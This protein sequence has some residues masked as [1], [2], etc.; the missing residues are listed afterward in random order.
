[1][2]WAIETCN[3]FK[4]YDRI[5]AITDLTLTVP[6][7]SV[8]GLIGPNGAGKSTL[9]RMLTGIVRPDQ[10]DAF[11][12]GRSIKEKTGSIRQRVG[13][14]PDVPTLYPSFSVADMFRLGCRL[15]EGWDERRCYE[16]KRVFGLPTGQ[17]VR[18]LSRSQKVQL[19]LVMALSLRPRLLILDEPTAGLDPVIRRG[20]LQSVIEEVAERGTTVFYSTHN[21]NDLEQSADHI[22]ALHQGN[23]LFSRSLD[24]LKESIHRLQVMFARPQ[25]E[26][27]LKTIPGLIDCQHKGRIFTLTVSGELDAIK[28]QPVLRAASLVEKVDLSLEEMFVA[29]MKAHG[30]SFAP[31][32]RPGGVLSGREED[33]K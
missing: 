17:L 11:I 4:S 29:L 19:A 25:T 33:A 27:N 2:D 10:G 28:N 31:D 32:Y 26:E 20:F 6:E 15:Y 22:A 24:E 14:V 23:L 3:L 16:L 5:K 1:M 30:Y 7:G 9:I 18:N 12:L 13:Y 21:L 8:F